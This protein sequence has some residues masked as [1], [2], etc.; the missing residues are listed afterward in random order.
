MS[1]HSGVGTTLPSWHLALAV[2]IIVLAAP[3]ARADQPLWE[4]GLGLG[5]L[6]LPHYR[7]SEQSHDWLLPLPYAVYRGSI[8]RADRDGTRAVLLDTDRV[9][10]D[11]SLDASPPTRNGDNRARA[12][13]PD[14]APTLQFGPRLNMMLAKGPGWKLELRVPWR[15]TFAVGSPARSV[16]WTATPVLNFDLDRQGWNI[17]LQGGPQAA[18]RRHHAYYYEVDPAYASA[19][20]PAYRAGRG[21]AGWGATASASG[22]L[23]D[24]WLATFLRADS[25]SGATFAG[26]PLVTQRSNL[27]FGLAASWVFKVSDERVADRR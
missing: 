18:S 21:F 25:V 16:G 5:A 8:F 24:W 22:R 17:G 23:G 11:L 19:A 15:A 9:T 27:T 7:G 4:L 1:G 6:R 3:A 12:G 10:F 14:L 13:M 2:S 20:R 26:S